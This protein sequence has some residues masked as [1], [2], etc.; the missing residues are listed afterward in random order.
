MGRDYTKN[1]AKNQICL[2]FTR[3]WPEADAEELELEKIADGYSNIVHIV[4][5]KNPAITEPAVVILRHYG[6]NDMDLTS[7]ATKNTEAEETMIV[8]EMSV[9]GWGPKTV[10]N[11]PRRPCGRIHRQSQ[12]GAAGFARRQ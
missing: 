7:W 11:F 8:Q 3:E 2:F 6:G 10:R 4:R 1:Y 5:R 12:P 9:R